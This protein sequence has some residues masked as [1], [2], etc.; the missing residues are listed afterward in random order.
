MTLAIQLEA[1]S[2]GALGVSLVNILSF[3]RDLNYLIRTWTDLETSLGAI[4]RVRS[5]EAETPCEHL[6]DENST[7]PAQ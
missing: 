1:T 2:A 6:P 4:S 3:S 7:P 5:F